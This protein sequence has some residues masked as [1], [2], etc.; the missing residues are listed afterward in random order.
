VELRPQ[1]LPGASGF[2]VNH[3]AFSQQQDGVA[4]VPQQP[5]PTGRTAVMDAEAT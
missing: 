1:V 2:R 3:A 5:V 4:V